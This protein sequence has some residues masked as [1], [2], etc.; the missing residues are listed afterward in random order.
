MQKLIKKILE[1]YPQCRT[2]K[3]DIEL[4]LN[5]YKDTNGNAEETE[6]ILHQEPYFSESREYTHATIIK[7]WRSAGLKIRNQGGGIG[8]KPLSQKDIDKI[9]SCFEF[10]KGNAEEASRGLP[11]SNSTISKYWKLGGLY[12]NAKKTN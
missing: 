4:I 8:R 3:E 2:P 1:D 9:V 10:F 7:F 6:R 11:Y 5:L 12:K